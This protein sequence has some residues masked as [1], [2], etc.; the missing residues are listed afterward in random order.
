VISD[1]CPYSYSD[2]KSEIEQVVAAVC[3]AYK[4]VRRAT[5]S[6]NEH[7][8]HRKKHGSMSAAEADF[9]TDFTSVAS[10]A[11][12][13]IDYDAAYDRVLEVLQEVADELD[14]P[15]GT[16]YECED[17]CAVADHYGYARRWGGWTAHLCPEFFSRYIG[18]DDQMKGIVHELSHL[19]EQTED[20][21]ISAAERI[22]PGSDML[23]TADRLS[24]EQLRNHAATIASFAARHQIE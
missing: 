7:A 2:E 24:A 12:G 4:T 9:R 18:A 5:A 3:S 21:G 22:Y 6:M 20:Y 11:T 1:C 13:H 23:S 16:Y 15:D 14:D 17:E 19:Y 10:S 8:S